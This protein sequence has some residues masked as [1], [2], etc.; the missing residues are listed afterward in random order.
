MKRYVLY[1]ASGHKDNTGADIQ[2]KAG[3]Y[4]HYDIQSQINDISGYAGVYDVHP[5]ESVNDDGSPIT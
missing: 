5:S 1:N 3:P 4:S 2:F